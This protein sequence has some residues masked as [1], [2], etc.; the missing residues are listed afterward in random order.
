MLQE[1]IILYFSNLVNDISFHLQTAGLPQS[2]EA[3]HDARVGIKKI[4]ALLKVFDLENKN[5]KIKGILQNH[6]GIIFKTAGKLRDVEIQS[7]LLK[8]YKNLLDHGY[9]D[10][11]KNLN[12]KVGKRQKNLRKKL[13]ERK[14]GFLKILEQEVRSEIESVAEERIDESIRSYLDKATRKIIKNRSR[15][16]PKVLHKQRRLLKEIRFCLEMRNLT[17]LHP[18]TGEQISR[19]KEMED[20]LGSWH[21]YNNLNKSVE[22]LMQK[23]KNSDVDKVIKMNALSHTISNDIILLLDKYRKTIPDLEIGI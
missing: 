7:Y 18:A 15:I 8:D 5:K 13:A 3:V 17:D 21:D 16:N 6:I 11:E 2:T 23:L 1:Q 12:N 9:S 4:H 22:K 20:L 10:L 14:P 19:I